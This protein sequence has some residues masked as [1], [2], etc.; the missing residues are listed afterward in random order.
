MPDIS[1]EELKSIYLYDSDTGKFTCKKFGREVGSIYSDGYRYLY[2]NTKR[3]KAHRLAFL[4][5]TGEMPPDQVDHIN[6]NKS[7]NRWCNLRLATHAENMR[8][9]STT[10]LSDELVATIRGRYKPRCRKDGAR[11][12]AREFGLHH[13]T[14]EKVIRG[15]LWT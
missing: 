4:Y 5:M 7:D 2:V 8:N 9:R 10:K 15:Q 1:Q 11:A 6:R 14:V 3:S 12:M 13:D